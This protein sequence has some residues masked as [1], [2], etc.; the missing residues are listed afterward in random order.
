[1]NIDKV[2][3]YLISMFG[4]MQPPIVALGPVANV[5]S[6]IAVNAERPDR[7]LPAVSTSGL[8]IS[9]CLAVLS[10]C[11]LCRFAKW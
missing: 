1:M 11:S 8:V 7:I 9:F 2:C 4:L 5:S 10:C 3:Y 6:P